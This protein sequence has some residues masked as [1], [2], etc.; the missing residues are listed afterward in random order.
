MILIGLLLAFAGNKFINA[1][2]FLIGSVAV[3]AVGLFFT[4]SLIDKYNSKPKEY[5]E[6]IIFVAFVILGMAVGGLLV[7]NR[8]FGIGILAAWGGVMIGLLIT[9]MFVMKNVYMY[10]GI[11]ASCAIILFIIAFKTEKIVIILVTSFIGSY[12][13][14]RGI[15]MY[16]GNFPDET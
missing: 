1:T 9:T 13:F 4:F 7:K 2:I 12:A 14:I 16:A 5:I 6:W 3:A 8:K 11:I 15:S 10:Y